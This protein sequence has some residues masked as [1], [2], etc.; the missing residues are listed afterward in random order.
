[1]YVANDEG[2]LGTDTEADPPTPNHAGVASPGLSSPG[3]AF[4]PNLVPSDV[5]FALN[6]A[7][8]ISAPTGLKGFSVVGEASPL[9]HTVATGIATVG[10]ASAAGSSAPT[11]GSAA[12]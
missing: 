1:V 10:R 7:P 5:V 12:P 11:Y 8:I 4:A 2:G 9:E 3:A 6:S